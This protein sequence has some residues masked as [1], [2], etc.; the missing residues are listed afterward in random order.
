[1][2]IDILRLQTF[3]LASSIPEYSSLLLVGSGL[4]GSL[5]RKRV[6]P[7]RGRRLGCEWR[8]SCAD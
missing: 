5:A 1:M 7:R 4:L 3:S 6:F 8:A 2:R